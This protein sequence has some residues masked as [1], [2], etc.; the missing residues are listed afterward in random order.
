FV[1]WANIGSSHPVVTWRAHAL[2]DRSKPG[3][4][5][6]RPTGALYTSPLPPGST[7]SSRYPTPGDALAMLA[8]ADAGRPAGHSGQFGRFTGIDYSDRPS[9]RAIP[10]AAPPLS[11]R[12]GAA[13]PP[14]SSWP[15]LPPTPAAALAMLAAADAGRPAGHSGQFGRFT[16][17]D[18]S[19]RPSVRAIQTAAPLLSGRTGYAIPPGPYRDDARGPLVPA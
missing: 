19:D 17:I 14:G 4:L 2:R 13:H 6:I 15:S 1:H 5:W 16:G 10:T 9:V 12:T 3:S 11:R 18:Y 7:W 8:A